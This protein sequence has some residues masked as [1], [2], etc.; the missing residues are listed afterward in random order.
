MFIN[1][2]WN[3]VKTWSPYLSWRSSGEWQDWS[4][5]SKH[6]RITGQSKANYGKYFN[7][8]CE[9]L[10][11][12]RSECATQLS[13]CVPF[14]LCVNYKT[15]DTVRQT[16]DAQ[17]LKTRRGSEAASPASTGA[18]PAGSC[19]FSEARSGRSQTVLHW[20]LVCACVS[21]ALAADR[22]GSS[23]LGRRDSSAMESYDVIANQPVVID[24]VSC[25][26][27]ISKGSYAL[28]P[29]GIACRLQPEP[30][31]LCHWPGLS[32]GFSCRCLCLPPTHS[33][34]AGRPV[35]NHG[36][37]SFGVNKGKT[38][39]PSRALWPVA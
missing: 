36:I 2:L 15:Q 3:K 25:V 31:A 6:P 27:P 11:D 22:A 18:R 33:P 8:L 20:R 30:P 1:V 28:L 39:S 38:C 23:F 12:Y 35:S 24:N 17:S 16:S 4:V 34:Q 21:V 9:S 10:R 19:S 32:Y 13:I 5:K 37:E 26:F 29:E 7:T 14:Y